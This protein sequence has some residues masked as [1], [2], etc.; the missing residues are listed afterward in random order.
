MVHDLKSSQGREI[1]AATSQIALL[2]Y[3][4]ILKTVFHCERAFAM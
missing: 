3:V 1:M 2:K 4:C